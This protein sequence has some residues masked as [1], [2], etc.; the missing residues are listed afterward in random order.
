MAS[1][2]PSGDTQPKAQMSA[3]VST[4]LPFACSGAM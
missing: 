3:R 1:R 2:D 4:G